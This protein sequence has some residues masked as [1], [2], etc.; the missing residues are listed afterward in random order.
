MR[1]GL[2]ASFSQMLSHAYGEII[3]AAPC[4]ERCV[5][6]KQ[7]SSAAPGHSPARA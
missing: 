1:L 3:L 5:R 6:H 7:D 2:F 4:K